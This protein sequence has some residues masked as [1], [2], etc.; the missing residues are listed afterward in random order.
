MEQGHHHRKSEPVAEPTPGTGP[1][2][3][4]VKRWAGSGYKSTN[5]ERVQ[6]RSQ[7]GVIRGTPMGVWGKGG[8]ITKSNRGRRNR[9]HSGNEGVSYR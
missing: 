7:G 1:G 5:R 8:L 4:A 6:R 3:I 2:F 9:E